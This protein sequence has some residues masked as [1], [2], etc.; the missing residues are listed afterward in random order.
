MYVVSNAAALTVGVMLVW[1]GVAKLRSRRVFRERLADY[2]V[3]PYF[4]T[5]SVSYILPVA[6]VAAGVMLLVPPVHVYGAGIATGLLSAFTVVLI[7]LTREG[8][9]VICGCFGGNEELDR[10]GLPAIVR[11]GSLAV[12]AALALMSVS[13]ISL[14]AYVLAPVL[15]VL[16]Q[17]VAE[18]TRLALYLVEEPSAGESI[19]A[20]SMEEI[21]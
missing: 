9:N 10:I 18:M 15:I 1:A 3:M 20:P 5:S 2:R 6:E 17:L 19:L 7:R 8:R 11:T 14:S 21:S 12:L 4:A 16:I 13:P